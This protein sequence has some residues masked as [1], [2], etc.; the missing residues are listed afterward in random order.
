M[1]LTRI[2][3]ENISNTTIEIQDLSANTVNVLMYTAN[4]GGGGAIS[5]GFNPF[6]LAGM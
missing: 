3:T 6:L 1:P 4:T 5:S 2:T